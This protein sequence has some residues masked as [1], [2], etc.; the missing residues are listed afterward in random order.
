MTSM[1]MIFS[2]GGHD[3]ITKSISGHDPNGKFCDEAWKAEREALE[4]Y[5]ILGGRYKCRGTGVF[6]GLI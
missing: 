6:R 1:S 3:Q 2:E 4:L 5:R